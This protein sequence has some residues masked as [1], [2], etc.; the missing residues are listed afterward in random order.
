MMSYCHIIC[1]DVMTSYGMKLPWCTMSW[2]D[3]SWRH[4]SWHHMLWQY[5][6]WCQMSWY[7]KFL[8]LMSWCQCHPIWHQMSYVMMSDVIMLYLM[9]SG[10]RIKRLFWTYTMP[11]VQPLPPTW[12]LIFYSVEWLVNTVLDFVLTF[13]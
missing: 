1:L 3:K 13:I 8:R 6:L 7:H 2:C 12:M 11:S 9:T 10:W 4:V 5:I